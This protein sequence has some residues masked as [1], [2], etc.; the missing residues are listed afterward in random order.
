MATR[1]LL[2][3][4]FLLT[5]C[6]SSADAEAP[7]SAKTPARTPAKTPAKTSAKAPASGSA[8]TP[9]AA[10]AIACDR[11]LTP[12]DIDAACVG[13][14]ATIVASPYET[15]EG[16]FTCN[17]IIKV[18]RGADQAATFNFKVS[19]YQSLDVVRQM[20]DPAA[21]E[22]DVER[23]QELAIGDRGWSYREGGR[24][25]VGAARG[26]MFVGIG[27]AYQDP[28]RPACAEAA[29]QSLAEKAMARLP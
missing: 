26:G 28:R 12:A 22:S 27:T 15:G 19:R 10:A 16:I 25:S 18:P 1:S 23:Y 8:Q 4:P 7:A 20:E 2:V 3:L 21:Y 11:L 13:R 29:L 9:A 6:G 17:R 24:F 5:G 14:G